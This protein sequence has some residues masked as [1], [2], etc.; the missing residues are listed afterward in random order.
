MAKRM[1]YYNDAPT[2]N[3]IQIVITPPKGSKETYLTGLTHPWAHPLPV[4]HAANVPLS[5][6]RQAYLL[7]TAK[8]EIPLLID[9]DT[10]A[11]AVVAR[12]Q[13]GTIIMA[14][15]ASPKLV[16]W[17]LK[18]MGR[19]T[20]TLNVSGVKV[21]KTRSVHFEQYLRQKLNRIATNSH[22]LLLDFADTGQALIKIKS[23]IEELRGDLRVQTFGMYAVRP[24]KLEDQEV[25][26]KV[27]FKVI[28]GRTFLPLL[29]MQAVKVFLGRNKPKNM[30][31]DWSNSLNIQADASRSQ[32]QDQKRAYAVALTVI[33][34]ADNSDPFELFMDLYETAYPDRVAFNDDPDECKCTYCNEMGELRKL[35]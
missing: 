30:Y 4:Y 16:K 25:F 34:A 13:V 26:D 19:V 27:D 15:G 17:R 1:L 21:N 7:F 35:N 8:L 32:F 5:T 24:S 3:A 28:P 9:V 22:V 12:C 14:I 10:V 11:Q 31:S 18:Q 33:P 29:Q 20:H 2:V 6:L 23:D